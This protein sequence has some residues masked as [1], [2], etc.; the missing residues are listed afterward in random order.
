MTD[1]LETDFSSDRS[2]VMG[3]RK[4][5]TEAVTLEPIFV[6]IV[7]VFLG[8]VSFAAISLLYMERSD[9]RRRMLQTD[10]VAIA[11]VMSITANSAPLL[12][13]FGDLDTCSKDYL[14][15][16]LS[17]A[18]FKLENDTA[19]LKYVYMICYSSLISPLGSNH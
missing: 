9:R 8:F 2:E 19:G 10:P 17:N 14:D 15:Q 5:Q 7:E 3:I 1:I 4:I 18:R 6:Y 11:A 13:A 12:S 16:K